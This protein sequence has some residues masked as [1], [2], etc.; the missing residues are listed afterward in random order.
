MSSFRLN[1]WKMPQNWCQNPLTLQTE[2]WSPPSQWPAESG[3]TFGRTMSACVHGIIPWKSLLTGTRGKQLLHSTGKTPASWNPA[4]EDAK[5]PWLKIRKRESW[6]F[7]PP[8]SS[9]R[10]TYKQAHELGH[11]VPTFFFAS[12]FDS[13]WH[14]LFSF[15][16][17][18]PGKFSLP[19]YFIIHVLLFSLRCWT[20]SKQKCLKWSFILKTLFYSFLL[21]WWVF[22]G[23]LLWIICDFNELWLDKTVSSYNKY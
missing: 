15:F 10:Y 19:R 11:R 6:F 12:Y 4:L 9:L 16:F 13:P 7:S 22:S 23:G 18:F 3:V 20:V 2:W 8:L 1:M 17:F 14:Y 21:P 5:E